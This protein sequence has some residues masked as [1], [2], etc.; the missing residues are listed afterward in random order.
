MFGLFDPSGC[1]WVQMYHTEFSKQLSG[2]INAGIVAAEDLSLVE[3]CR[4]SEC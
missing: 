4:L 1:N 2:S 3:K